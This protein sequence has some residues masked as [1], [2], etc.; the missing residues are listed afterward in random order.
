MQ[1]GSQRSG[2]SQRGES[3]IDKARALAQG[4]SNKARLQGG[5]WH[6]DLK[7]GEEEQGVGRKDTSRLSFTQQTTSFKAVAKWL[8]ETSSGKSIPGL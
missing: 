5:L 3:S 8:L 2:H 4:A 1:N 7:S 6:M